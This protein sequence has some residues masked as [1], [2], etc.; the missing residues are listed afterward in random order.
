[1]INVSKNKDKFV[2]VAMP[3]HTMDTNGYMYTRRNSLYSLR[4]TLHPN[5]ILHYRAMKTQILKEVPGIV[6]LHVLKNNELPFLMVLVVGA[7]PKYISQINIMLV[8]LMI[9][10]KQIWKIG[11]SHHVSRPHAYQQNGTIERKHHHIIEIYLVCE[12]SASLKELIKFI[13][14]IFGDKSDTMITDVYQSM[15]NICLVKYSTRI[16]GLELD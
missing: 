8:I 15:H 14:Y 1:M 9:L 2:D 16:R 7:T 13:A 11:M 6:I 10:C 12:I 3:F 4:K 5:N